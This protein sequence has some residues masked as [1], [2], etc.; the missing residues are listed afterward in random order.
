MQ[1]T[2]MTPAEFA[3]ALEARGLAGDQV[4]TAAILGVAQSTISKWLRGAAPI[5]KITAMAIEA[6]P[7]VGKARAK[8]SPRPSRKSK[9]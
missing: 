2:T 1:R 6:I 4:R 5:S 8:T 3:A 9:K 7:V